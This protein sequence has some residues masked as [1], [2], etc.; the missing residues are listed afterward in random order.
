MSQNVSILAN[1]CV[2]I[3]WDAPTLLDGRDMS[4]LIKGKVNS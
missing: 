1:S 2:I 3:A 4:W